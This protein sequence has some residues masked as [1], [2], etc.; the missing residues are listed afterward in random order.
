MSLPKYYKHNPEDKLTE[1]IMINA[2]RYFIMGER[3]YMAFCPRV[4]NFFG[5]RSESDVIAINPNGYLVEFEVKLTKVDF[6]KDKDKIISINRKRI[7]K[8]KLYEQGGGSAMFYFV[9]PKG[10]LTIDDIPE[11][12]GLIEVVSREYSRE[13]IKHGTVLVC[14]NVKNAKKLNK[15]KATQKEIEK[16][17]RLLSFKTT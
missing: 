3:N 2:L 6:L 14:N 5:M 13:Y 10:I 16:L 11:W 12:A 15:R 17:L 7:N 9:A 8:H 4:H 1:G